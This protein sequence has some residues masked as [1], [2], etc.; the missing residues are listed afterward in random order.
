MHLQSGFVLLIVDNLFKKH[1]NYNVTSVNNIRCL[2]LQSSQVPTTITEGS[3]SYES[4]DV[5]RNDF[6]ENDESDE[7][8]GN[9]CTY[10]ALAADV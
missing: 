10:I 3:S 2:I 8:S 4:S 9:T 1:N 7:V 6:I 5:E